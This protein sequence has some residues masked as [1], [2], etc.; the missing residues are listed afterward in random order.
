MYYRLERRF[1]RTTLHRRLSDSRLPRK[2]DKNRFNFFD[3][4]LRFLR[5]KGRERRTVRNLFAR[6]E[7]HRDNDGLR[8]TPLTL[9]KPRVSTVES[10]SFYTCRKYGVTGYRIVS[11]LAAFMFDNATICMNTAHTRRD[12]V[13]TAPKHTNI[14]IA[15]VLCVC[16][17][18]AI[19]EESARTIL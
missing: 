11:A 14:I 8:S 9:T 19:R 18:C 10:L 6:Q 7:A 16:V 1:V 12:T 4:P 2:F 13:S 5:S 15:P 3:Q 17:C